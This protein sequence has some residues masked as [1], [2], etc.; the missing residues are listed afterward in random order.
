M[1]PYLTIDM[2][3]LIHKKEPGA[4]FQKWHKDFKLGPKIT[5]TIVV[6]LA[7]VNKSATC[8][9]REQPID[10]TEMN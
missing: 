9:L 10:L 3:W 4:G 8:K 7:C 5:N 1:F 2:V 6:N